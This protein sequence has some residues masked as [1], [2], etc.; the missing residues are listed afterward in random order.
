MRSSIVAIH[1][2][3]GHRE[4]TWTAENN[5]NWLRDPKMLPSL[6][7]DARIMSWGYDAH[8]HSTKELSAMYLYDH[9]QKLIS[10]L[11]LQRHGDKVSSYVLM[12]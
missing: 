2:L 7:P 6:I 11:S 1:G 5:V 12:L 8:T 3:N 4:Q 9:G 10:D